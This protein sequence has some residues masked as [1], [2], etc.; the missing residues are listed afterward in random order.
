MNKTKT[1]IIDI[2]CKITPAVQ[3]HVNINIKLGKLHP[4]VI[5]VDFVVEI[6]EDP[7]LPEPDPLPVPLLPEPPAPLLVIP[8]LTVTPVPLAPPETPLEPTITL[9]EPPP[10]AFEPLLEV[11]CPTALEAVFAF[12]AIETVLEADTPV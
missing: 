2:A 10:A 3:K 5:L 9:V 8:P 6:I 11:D 7:K 12:D 4:S 1:E